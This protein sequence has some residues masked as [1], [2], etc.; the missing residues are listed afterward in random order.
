M[1]IYR[2]GTSQWDYKIQVHRLLIQMLKDQADCHSL[3]SIKTASKF[4][5][6]KIRNSYDAPKLENLM[7]MLNPPQNMRLNPPRRG[8]NRSV[9]VVP[10]FPQDFQGAGDTLIKGDSI[11]NTGFLPP[12]AYN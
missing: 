5:F 1:D 6:V 12:N 10:S 9:S 4:S 3:G 8:N 2:L 7:K 11:Y